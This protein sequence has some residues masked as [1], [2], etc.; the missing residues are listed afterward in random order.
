MDSGRR[1]EVRNARRLRR[2]RRDGGGNEVNDAESGRSASA[3]V[4][5]RST[6]PPLGGG[7]G[8]GMAAAAAAAAGAGGGGRRRSGIGTSRDEAQRLSERMQQ[9]RQ[10]KSRAD[11][12]LSQR[13]SLIRERYAPNAMAA[14]AAWGQGAPPQQQPQLQAAAYAFDKDY[15]LAGLI[16]DNKANFLKLD[17]DLTDDH[18]IATHRLHTSVFAHA[19][20]FLLLFRDVDR[21]SD[22]VEALKAN[23]QGTK[24][25]ISS[26]SK[27]SSANIVG[28]ST[29][30]ASSAS[31]GAG[32]GTGSATADIRGG[33]ASG[34]GG[35]AGGVFSST[36]GGAAGDGDP[37]RLA[38]PSLVSRRLTQRYATG[39][40]ASDMT[41][42]NEGGAGFGGGGTGG[43]DGG[44]GKG[45]SGSA[46]AT[47]SHATTWA[48]TVQ[49]SGVNDEDSG[50]AAAASGGGADEVAANAGASRPT[51]RGLNVSSVRQWRHTIGLGAGS[52]AGAEAG[53]GDRDGNGRT[54]AAAGR[55][56]RGGD[57]GGARALLSGPAT[58]AAKSEKEA[59][60]T[61]AFVDILRE[62]VNQLLTERRHV[63]A[64]E[65]LYRLADEATAKGCVPFLL[66]LEAALVSSVISNVVKIPV[67]PTYVE[68]LHV[69][70]IQLLLR[71]GRSRSAAAV[72]LTMHTSWLHNE[73][74]KLQSRVNPQYASLIAVDF[75]VRA[76]RATVRRQHTL[77]L[78]LAAARP[79]MEDATAGSPGA[80][81]A[82]KLVAS[83][84]RGAVPPAAAAGAAGGPV[85]TRKVTRGAGASGAA[86]APPGSLIPPNSAALLWVRRN[87]ERFACEVLA[88]HLLSFGTGTDGGDPTRI[89]QAAQMIAQTSRVMQ[90]LSTDGFA[91]CDT[92]I[93]RQLTPSLVILEDDFTRLTGERLEHGGR[94]MVE[95]LIMG[96]LA[97]YETVQANTAAITVAAA[98]AAAYAAA[99]AVISSGPQ[100]P[101]AGAAPSDG[102]KTSAASAAAAQQ[103][104][105]MPA[106]PPPPRITPPYQPSRCDDVARKA[107]VR[108]QEF[109]QL[110]RALPLSG[111]SLLVQLLLAPAS[112]SLFKST[113]SAAAGGGGGAGQGGSAAA[114]S[115]A[116]GA[117]AATS[118]SPGVVTARRG[119]GS[120]GS[121]TFRSGTGGGGGRGAT[122]LLGKAGAPSASQQVPLAL[123]SLLFATAPPP[124]LSAERFRFL[125]YANGCSGTQVRLLRS[126][127]GYVAALTGTDQ[128][129]AEVVASAAAQERESA[130]ANAATAMRVQ[131]A[132]CVAYLLTNAMVTESID[133]VLCNLLS[134]MMTMLLRQRKALVRFL[135]SDAFLAN[136]RRVFPSASAAAA[137]KTTP[138]VSDAPFFSD[139]AISPAWVLDCT[140][141]LLS[142]VVS[143]GTW[144]S[145]F[146]RGGAMTHMLADVQFGFRTQHLERVQRQIPRLVQ[147]WLCA[148]L[149][150]NADVTRAGAVLAPSARAA[151]AQAAARSARASPAVTPLLAPQQSV[152]FG[153]QPPDRGDGRSP[154]L[155]LKNNV[156]FSAVAAAAASAAAG[157]KSTKDTLSDATCVL[158][159]IPVTSPSPSPSPSSSAAAAA[160]GAGPAAVGA[161]DSVAAPFF[162]DAGVREERV[163]KLV[164]TFL[165]R[166]YRTPASYTVHHYVVDSVNDA[167]A[168]A[169]A[170]VWAVRRHVSSYPEFPI[171][172]MRE[173]RSD[174]VFL[175]H[176]CTQISLHLLTFFQERLI[177]PSYA[178]NQ[179]AAEAQG[180]MTAFL[181][182]GLPFP[183]KGCI[184]PQEDT[185]LAALCAGG[186]NYVAAVA[187]LQFLVMRLLRDGLCRADTWS[188]VYGCSTAQWRGDEAVLRQQLFFFALFGYLW[189]PLFTG[190]RRPP[191]KPTGAAS[192]GAGPAASA[193]TAKDDAPVSSY[194][195]DGLP[196]LAVL[197]W[198]T[199]GGVLGAPANTDSVAAAM[200][201]APLATIPASLTAIDVLFATEGTIHLG[202]GSGDGVAGGAAAGVASA[203]ATAGGSAAWKAKAGGG[204]AAAAAA[205]G[206][207]AHVPSSTSANTTLAKRELF[208]GGAAYIP[209]G[210]LRVVRHFFEDQL[211]EGR[212]VP[213]LTSDVMRTRVERAMADVNLLDF[214]GTS[215][216]M[217]DDSDD[218]AS[219]STAARSSAGAAAKSQKV[220]LQNL[221]DLIA[222][223][224]VP[225]S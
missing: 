195:V 55:R 64:A 66:D 178:M 91:G 28:G 37:R 224:A 162:T 154:T 109:V 13:E 202:A 106:R 97:L 124:P 130:S 34:G 67:T 72:Y 9:Q 187:L 133:V 36:L 156:S 85:T 132:E 219:S 161:K 138:V 27:Y 146:T 189:A 183:L 174:E 101:A 111:H 82:K 150:L 148:T 151:A 182:A 173:H 164:M 5:G 216:G 158:M 218:S 168:G 26:I 61:A 16:G 119:S 160:A 127:C 193:P 208:G 153:S 21:A 86:A 122:A 197:E 73:V 96:S 213:A 45:G 116:A 140:L 184:T 20:S 98:A 19:N 176:W 11:E 145:F 103:Q 225:L 46:V 135:T 40:G 200:A 177:T 83:P 105:Q 152:L 113:S 7:A 43:S 17:H 80:G 129:P 155:N 115:T 15:L 136:H 79:L 144:V 215:L 10:V 117:G 175:L 65:L 29:A 206:G 54:A 69:P 52:G 75:L 190:G 167:G 159:S 84:V 76:T 137:A 77:G 120:G 51:T 89:R 90:A 212:A 110:I 56:L 62:E 131:Q 47:S 149:L 99:V 169:L 123:S 60:D 53:P 185:V 18:T 42:L 87:V 165:D 44:A 210:P 25:A 3:N 24:A 205:A 88:T 188:A 199:C 2:S 118:S 71:F 209:D 63:D 207:A 59:T 102:K 6:P 142:D 12:M 93:L 143:L 4:S 220:T 14:T 170:G 180:G 179:R 171:G 68:S 163:L 35:G 23:V 1:R 191:T 223:Y 198:M 186:G 126:V 112:S 107:R 141:C 203:S 211:G 31:A 181:N 114:A 32:K 33:G 196:P 157:K 94:A 78:P 39:G 100:P 121:V 8:A 125:R 74:Q 38:R 134:R 147:G 95:Q 41:W 204:S 201:S 58:A 139:P 104:Q 49:R 30:A 217:D 92:L 128:L 194:L 192:R 222:T 22:L 172:E 221:R 70:L 214:V 57:A 48:S 166:K 81:D 50:G 108:C